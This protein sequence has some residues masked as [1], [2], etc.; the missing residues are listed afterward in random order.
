MTTVYARYLLGEYQNNKEKKKVF[1]SLLHELSRE[2][3][4]L[5]STPLI[6]GIIITNDCNLH[7]PHCFS[8]NNN[9]YMSLETFKKVVDDLYENDVISIYITGGEPFLH[10]NIIEMIS[11]IKRYNF[12]LTIHTNAI[13]IDDEIMREVSKLLDENDVIQV[14]IDGAKNETNKK[15]RTMTEKDFITLKSNCTNMSNLGINIKI[16]TTVTNHNI[17]E[18]IDIYDLSIAIGAK[19]ISYSSLFDLGKIN[20]FVKS[21]KIKDTIENFEDLIKYAHKL[22]FPVQIVQDPLAV[23]CGNKDIVNY[24]IE[25]KG[26][27][28]LPYY[29]CP[30]GTTA[31]EINFDGEVYS[32]P[33]LRINDFSAGNINKNSLKFIWEKGENWQNLRSRVTE[34]YKKGCELSD[35]CRGA[36]PAQSYYLTG[37]IDKCD[38]RCEKVNVKWK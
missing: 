15:M 9:E 34:G 17:L 38:T 12:Y 22:N 20:S 33:F 18:L 27:E 14:S 7:C 16:N 24:I 19:A 32:C 4:I 29:E 2:N 3:N 23:S 30:A 8:L 25:K 28:F 6:A 11:Y 5:L 10:P 36:C 1:T 21:P 13:K 26:E 31:I 37:N 35:I